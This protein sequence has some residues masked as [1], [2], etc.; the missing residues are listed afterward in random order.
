MIGAFGFLAL[1]FPVIFNHRR[2][3]FLARLTIHLRMIFGICFVSS[4]TLMFLPIFSRPTGLLMNICLGI[5]VLLAV[6]TTTY[7]IVSLYG[8]YKKLIDAI[9]HG[10]VDISRKPK[11]MSMGKYRFP[12]NLMKMGFTRFGEF[13]RPEDRDDETITWLYRHFDFTIVAEIT[14]VIEALQYVTWFD[15]GFRVQTGFP[16]GENIQDEHFI[17]SF[18]EAS[19][20]AAYQQHI[21]ITGSLQA[22]HGWSPVP[23]NTLQAWKERDQH[24]MERDWRRIMRRTTNVVRLR[25]VFGV[26][27]ILSSVGFIYA[28]HQFS[29]HDLWQFMIAGTVLAYFFNILPGWL[30]NYRRSPIQFG[31]L[32]SRSSKRGL[33]KS[34]EIVA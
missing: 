34:K 33:Q 31:V 16:I 29:E 19:M 3:T 25:I 11:Y 22:A 10:V 28:Y 2:W 24:H 32:G 15:N 8:H 21:E 4:L 26:Y 30:L 14:H 6:V 12:D 1:F 17:A 20:H 27:L 5:P 13:Q 18:T 23:I 9:E 7:F